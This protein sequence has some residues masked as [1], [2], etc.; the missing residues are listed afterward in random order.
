MK[1]VDFKF[2]IDDQ[3][4]TPFEPGIVTMMAFDEGGQK[5]YVQ[6]K[7]APGW[8]KEGQLEKA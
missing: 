7:S 2:E 3:V 1:T 6:T 8:F 5:Y 4:M